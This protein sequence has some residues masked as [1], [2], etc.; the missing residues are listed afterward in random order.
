MLWIA[1]VHDPASASRETTKMRDAC[2]L[3]AVHLGKARLSAN[4]PIPSRTIKQKIG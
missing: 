1:I 3:T 4:V 2:V